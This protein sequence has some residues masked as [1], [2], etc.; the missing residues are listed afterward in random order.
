MPQFHYRARNTRG[1]LMAG[2]LDGASA[3]AVANELLRSSLTPVDIREAGAQAGAGI[4]AYFARL[5]AEKIGPTDLML[6][7]RQMHSLLKAGVP[8]LRALTS[9]ADSA[10][11]PALREVLIDVRDGLAGGRELSAC[12]RR[13]PEVFSAFFVNMVR[14]GE[15]TG[16][17]DD[18]FLRLFHH[19]EFDREMHER[20]KGALRYPSFVVLALAVAIMVINIMVIP[21]F[22]KVY[23]S[24]NADLPLVTQAL[25]GVSNLT[26]AYW[27]WLL[28]L[29]V[30]AVAGFRAWVRTESGGYRWDKIKLGLPI[31]GKIIH[32]AT[33]ARFARGLAM[34]YASGVPIVQ[35]LNSVAEVVDNRFIASRVEQMRD[36]IE[37]GEA[38]SRTA[39]TTG[40][41]TPVV[42]QMLAIG[43]ETGDLEHLLTEIGDMYQKEVEYEIKTLSEQIEPI[44]IVTLGII[45]LIV[46]LG[47]FLP[48]WDLG[49]TIIRK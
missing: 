45:V 42:L 29:A 14:V 25:I 17:L 31:A 21:A 24:A 49:R 12:L 8:I 27:P 10:A 9:L 47:V 28:G 15:T 37:R 4:E 7:A 43:E 6:F 38:I 46:A 19:L 32:K 41:F 16:R 18:I 26:L 44:L 34:S 1:E 48:M 11:K 13:H 30:L 3:D 23:K 20:V 22:A 36:G 5:F 2:V 40:V 35:G 33:L 39:A